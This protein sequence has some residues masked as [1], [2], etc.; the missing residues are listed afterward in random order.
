M[1]AAASSAKLR[2]VPHL[3]AAI[4]KTSKMIISFNQMSREVVLWV[5]PYV[6][7]ARETWESS[8]PSLMPF[9]QTVE[10]AS[11]QVVPHVLAA[12]KRS[13][14]LR[15]SFAQILGRGVFQVLPFVPAAR[16][17]LEYPP[18]SRKI[19]YLL[20]YFNCRSFLLSIFWNQN[21]VW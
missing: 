13:Y 2:V 8:P 21:I 16:D 10:E 11:L 17:T 12:R 19:Y 20:C 14:Q 18:P 5:V 1:A 15:I 3:L 7:S 9:I 4:K 6:T